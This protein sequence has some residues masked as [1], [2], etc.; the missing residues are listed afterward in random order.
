LIEK[1]I[2]VLFDD[3]ENKSAGEK[4]SDADLIGIPLRVVVSDK[5]LEKGGV[6]IKN[7]NESESTIISVE[8]FLKEHN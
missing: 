7:R 6:E 8:E 3:R 4:F 2:E 1:N 5:S